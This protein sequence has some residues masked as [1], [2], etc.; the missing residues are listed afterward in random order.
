MTNETILHI[1]DY[2]KIKTKLTAEPK[3]EV[4]PIAYLQEHQEIYLVCRCCLN[5]W[6]EP[7]ALSMLKNPQWMCSVVCPDPECGAEG[8]IDPG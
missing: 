3:G 7:V 1:R 5:R 8:H 4:V 2:P 6:P